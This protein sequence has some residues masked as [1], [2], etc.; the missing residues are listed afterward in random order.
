M[1]VPLYFLPMLSSL[2]RDM[3]KQVKPRQHSMQGDNN[4]INIYAP[5]ALY[6]LLVWLRLLSLFNSL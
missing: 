5:V 4:S 2:S 1:A 3:R 6:A